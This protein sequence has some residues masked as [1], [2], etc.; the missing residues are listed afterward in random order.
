MPKSVSLLVRGDDGDYYIKNINGSISLSLD[1]AD[2]ELSDC[3]GYS[4]TFRFD[5]GDL[6]M[7][8]G[9]GKI[10]LDADD[11]DVRIYDAAFTSID[12]DIDD[13]SI[14]LE[15]SLSDNDSYRL[16]SQDGG[17]SLV[18]TAGGGEFDIS[19]DDAGIR[20]DDSFK[21]LEV[22]EEHTRLSLNNGKAKVTIRSDD[23]SI[24]LASK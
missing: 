17:I 11:S 10:Q 4:F 1:D 20:C 15:T 8:R 23:A 16:N 14:Y 18:V 24:K 21:K 7:N 3:G 12:A 6:K 2:A 13:G 22:S 19:H 9:K 5:D